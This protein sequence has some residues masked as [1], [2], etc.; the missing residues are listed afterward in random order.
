ML[1]KQENLH[2]PTTTKTKN[3]RT[4]GP[5]GYEYPF[6]VLSDPFLLIFLSNLAIFLSARRLEVVYEIKVKA[7]TRNIT[8]HTIDK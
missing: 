3:P 4:I 2:D 8:N 6:L 1:R 7:N 5:T